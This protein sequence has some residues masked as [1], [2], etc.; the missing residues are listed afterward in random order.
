MADNE[1]EHST[2]AAGPDLTG[3]PQ[4]MLPLQQMPPPQETGSQETASQETANQETTP[5]EMP[6]STA[7][8]HPQDEPEVTGAPAPPGI[9]SGTEAPAKA[10]GGAKPGLRFAALAATAIAGGILGFGGTLAM[11]QFEGSFQPGD[12]ASKDQIAALSARLDSIEGKTNTAV[13]PAALAALEARLA[14]AEQAASKAADLAN[15]AEADLQKQLASQPAA[16]PPQEGTAGLAASEAPDLGPLNARIDSLEQK[17]ASLQT[18]LTAPKA[19]LRASQ[20]EHESPLAAQGAR[21]QAIAVVAQSLLH[22]LESGMRFSDEL[23]HLEDLGV[24]AQSLAPLR[25]AAASSIS[26]EHQLA[27]QFKALAPAIIASDPAR[28]GSPDENFLDRVTRHAKDLVHI[29]RTGES[30][31]MDIESLVAHIEKDLAD[32]DLEGAY[33]TWSQLPS[34]AAAASQSWGDAAKTRL[35]ALNAARKI[36]SDAVAAVG[37]PKS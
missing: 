16:A 4:E 13:T 21:E 24:S 12:F 2:P 15:S 10:P 19:E 7:E 9:P 20:G 26:S 6:M 35:D 32:H 36:E 18:A 25:A 11:R 29:H 5:Q 34:P 33:Q 3:S 8:L 1:S 17:V 23:A 31:E 37:K 27:V 28:Q 30:E 14:S 22:K